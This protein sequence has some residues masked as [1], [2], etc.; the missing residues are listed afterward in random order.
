MKAWEYFSKSSK[1]KP[2]AVDEQILFFMEDYNKEQLTAFLN[3]LLKEGYC[4]SDVYSNENEYITV[5]DQFLNPKL[6]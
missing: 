6:K 5:I 3:F 4:D 1:K 2:I